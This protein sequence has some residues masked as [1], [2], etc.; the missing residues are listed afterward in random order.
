MDKQ[1]KQ[2]I[3]NEVTDEFRRRQWFN[4]CGFIND[5]ESL[6]IAYNYYPAFELKEIKENM[7]KYPVRF[8]LKDIRTVMPGSQKDDVPSHMR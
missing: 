1:Q 3:I 6:T 8:E 5:D 7:A 4:G 2:R